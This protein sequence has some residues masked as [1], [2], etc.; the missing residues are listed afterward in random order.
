M[1]KPSK[2]RCVTL[3]QASALS[4]LFGWLL[5]SQM[6]TYKFLIDYHGASYNLL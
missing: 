1:V 6:A 3:A 4:W 2:G 5:V